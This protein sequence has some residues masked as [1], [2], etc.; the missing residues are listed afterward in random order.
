M[1]QIP[2]L[3]NVEAA[4]LMSLLWWRDITKPQLCEL[5]IT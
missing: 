1:L 3:K 2:F 5:T 4:C